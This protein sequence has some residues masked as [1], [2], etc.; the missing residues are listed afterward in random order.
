MMSHMTLGVIGQ[1]WI[2]KNLADHFE[3]RGFPV[4][5]YAKETP[6]DTNRD[7]IASCE[8]VFIAVPTP[9]TASGFDDSIVRAVL[10]L[11]GVGKI[12]VIKS[13]VVP[14]TTDILQAEFPDIVILHA[15]E[16]LREATVRADIDHPERNIVGVPTALREHGRARAAVDAL[17]SVL[18]EAPYTSVGSAVEAELTKYASNVFLYTKVVFMNILYDVARAHGVTWSGLRDNLI[19]DPRIGASHMEPVHQLAHLDRA[20]GRGAGGH[21]FIK[22]FAAFRMVAESALATDA[23]ALAV[24]RALEEKN[25]ELLRASGKDAA[26]VNQVYGTTQP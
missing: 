1:G 10:P 21:C 8:V 6:Y 25:I 7:A 19:A 23:R 2:G 3:D 11:V 26:L 12:A 5:R 13:T 22:D 4:V 17:L 9:T 16:F 20:P 15:P 18:P 24:L 14:G